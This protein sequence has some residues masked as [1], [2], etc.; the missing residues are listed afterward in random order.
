MAD[1]FSLFGSVGVNN[2]PAIEGLEEV[3]NSVNETDNNVTRR[4]KSITSNLSSAMSK[5]GGVMLGAASVIGAGAV[6]MFL[7]FQ[8]TIAKVGTLVE[9]EKVLENIKKDMQRM[10]NDLGIDANEIGEAIYDGL[11]S[12]V[13]PENISEFTNNMAKLAKGGMAEVGVATDLY[14]GVA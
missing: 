8:E 12:G 3:N 14:F 1:I 10:S 13:T 11:S 7:P 6:T 4:G 2:R 5:V 9:D